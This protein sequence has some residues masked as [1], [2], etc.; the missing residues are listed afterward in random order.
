[1]AK[2]QQTTFLPT[3]IRVGSFDIKLK[4]QTNLTNMSGDEGSY[5]ESEQII[6]LDK[7]LIDLKNSYS[8]AL[9]WHEI[10]HAI[11]AQ[12]SLSGQVEEITVNS[13]SQG[14]VQVLRDNPEFN[15]WS[16]ECIT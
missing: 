16:K 9:I 12:Y 14:I 4:L 7:T 13:F 2:L 15:K 1:M 3:N 6:L 8:L 10:C 5:I 11:F